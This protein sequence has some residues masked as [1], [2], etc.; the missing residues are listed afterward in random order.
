MFKI[1]IIHFQKIDKS[2]KCGPN[3]LEIS[4]TFAVE[5]CSKRNFFIRLYYIPKKKSQNVSFSIPETVFFPIEILKNR[6]L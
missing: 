1:Y 5:K 2:S 4:K 6:S 3:L